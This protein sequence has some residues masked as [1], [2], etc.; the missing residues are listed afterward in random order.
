MGH[1][2][3]HRTITAKRVLSLKIKGRQGNM[4]TLLKNLYY[5]MPIVEYFFSHDSHI[6]SLY[7]CFGSDLHIEA[8]KRDWNDDN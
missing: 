5:L 3:L 1:D 7:D 2:L 4:S 6:C 8:H